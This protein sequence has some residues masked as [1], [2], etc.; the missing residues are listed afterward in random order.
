MHY[1][2]GFLSYSDTAYRV[3]SFG[4]EVLVSGKA[5]GIWL[6]EHRDYSDSRRLCLT[7]SGE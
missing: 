3:D 5:Q 7:L 6:G 1:I 4:G 2:T